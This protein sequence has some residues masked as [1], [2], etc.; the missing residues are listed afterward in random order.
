MKT[1]SNFIRLILFFLIGSFSF[2]GCVLDDEPSIIEEDPTNDLGDYDLPSSVQDLFTPSVLEITGSLE[3]FLDKIISRGMEINTGIRPPEI[4]K[5]I[6]SQDGLPLFKAPLEFRIKNDCIYDELYPSYADSTF[7]GYFDS[8]MI[9]KLEED[10]VSY[11]SYNSETDKDIY[12]FSNGYDQGRGV[13]IA[14]GEGL[15]FSVFYKVDDGRY[16]NISYQALWIISGT[17]D[18]KVQNREMAL[19]DVTKCMVLLSKGN[20][21]QSEMANVGTIRIFKDENPLMI[22]NPD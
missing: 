19:K 1:K 22:L 14:T 4:N 8:L 10:Y 17:F 11:V 15:K 18:L 3:P 6:S 16:G 9:L 21:P 7:G 12:P 20:D 2:F 13:G 5:T